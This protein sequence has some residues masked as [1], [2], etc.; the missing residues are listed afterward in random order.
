MLKGGVIMDVTTPEQARIAQ[1]A[2]ACA[3]LLEEPEPHYLR[4]I[5]IIEYLNNKLAIGDYELQ[6]PLIDAYNALMSDRIADKEQ[7]I[8]SILAIYGA[9][10][11]DPDAVDEDG[12]TAKDKIK[13]DKLLEL[14]ADSKAEY[15]TRIRNSIGQRPH[16]LKEVLVTVVNSHIMN[17]SFNSCFLFHSF[18]LV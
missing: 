7:F 8:D 12:N 2:G 11:G 6:I 14:P 1:E 16:S 3:A 17:V 5:P 15:L 9:L 18:F 13:K 10:L 4:E